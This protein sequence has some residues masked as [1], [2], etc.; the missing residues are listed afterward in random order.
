MSKVH[1]FFLWSTNYLTAL[2]Q[3]APLIRSPP[4]NLKKRKKIICVC[5]LSS[6]SNNDWY[7][8]GD[9]S[10]TLLHKNCQ[11]TVCASLSRLQSFQTGALNKLHRKY[12]LTFLSKCFQ[13]TR[14]S[15][16]TVFFLNTDTDLILL[17]FSLDILYFQPCSTITECVIFSPINNQC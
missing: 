15:L 13:C 8:A 10:C 17:P 5:T 2:T 12:I 3:W 9:A 16:P 4:T 1:S 6:T 14:M 7:A 11:N